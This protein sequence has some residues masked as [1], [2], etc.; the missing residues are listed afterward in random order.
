MTRS[1]TSEQ[2][3]RASHPDPA[4]DADR[5]PIQ[6]GEV[7]ENRV[8]RERAVILEL[9]WENTAG[10]VVADTTALRGARVVGEHVHPTL[11][12]RFSVLEGKLT[13]MRD[14][15]RSVW[16][17]GQSGHIEPGVWH[18]WW[19]AGETD[20]VVRVE[21]TPGERFAHLIETLFGL[22]REGHVNSKGMP[23]PLQLAL[24]IAQEFLG[25]DRV[26]QTATACT[27]HRV[28]RA[29][30]DRQTARVPRDLPKSVAY[31]AGAAATTPDIRLTIPLPTRSIGVQKLH[32]CQG[33]GGHHAHPF[34]LIPTL[35][36]CGSSC[37][38]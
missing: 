10:R 8:A 20:A 30:N 19:N 15:Q 12:E 11:H 13:V 24:L 1:L 31:H 21:A 36:R 4:G 34:G 32:H 33:T 28:R 25:C 5:Q 17:T 3:R 35:P 2:C 27:V 37:S 22:A 6:H 26:P 9:P 7:W 16:H 23:N 38:R 29:D 14:G 18:D